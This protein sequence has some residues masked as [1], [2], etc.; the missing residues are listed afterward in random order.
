MI[1]AQGRAGPLDSALAGRMLA[2]T[3]HRGTRLSVGQRGQ[4]LLGASR[5]ADLVDSSL[6]EDGD[7]CAV[8]GGTLDNAG[9]LCSLLT[10]AGHGP[11]SR[12]AADVL[13]AAFR[14]YG[15]AAVRRLRGAFAGVVT[16]GRRLWCFRDHLG[17]RP[18]FYHDG[19]QGFLAATEPK[20]ILAGAGLPREPDLE[21]LEQIFYGR[22]PADTPCALKGVRRLPQATILTVDADGTTTQQRYWHPEELL[23]T[24]SLS[25]GDVAD[26]FMELLERAVART[27][28]GEDVIALSGGV[29]SPAIAAFAAPLSAGTGRPISALSAV[30]PDFPT[31][32]ERCYIELVARHLNIGLHT[33]TQQ[34]RALNDVEHWARL[35]D[36]PIPIVSLPE[37]SEHYALARALGFRNILTGEFAEF[38][39][40]HRAHLTGHLLTHGRF[41]A[42]A[43]LIAAERRRGAGCRTIVREMLLPF[44][45]GRLA[46]WWF[47]RV[48][49]LNKPLHAPEWLARRKFDDS[50]YRIDLVPPGHRRWSAQQLVAFDGATITMEADEL[51]A[52]VNGV[53]AR[54]PFG[55]VDLWEFFLSLPAEIKF[56]DTRSKT[57][58]RRLLRGRVPDAILDRPRK[59]VFDD[60]V[61]SQVDYPALRRL[62]LAPNHQIDGVDY[63]CLA[64]HLER[65][66]LALFDWFWAKEL[67]VVHAFLSQC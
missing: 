38:V 27:L 8:V 16:D 34:A 47:G 65:E 5:G 39:C 32:D 36:G 15:P 67:A 1:A 41:R 14:A 7:L 66:D 58:V 53:T 10:D 19:P 61:V 29:D 35:M 40:D 57:L 45:P 59:T 18:L 49:H 31:V 62:L 50:P 43:Q 6:S 4:C 44:L 63:R 20:Q 42:L 56:P 26:K 52:A 28:T 55:D 2:T 54:R 22:M 37:I 12:A 13:V 3:P 60:H 46:N 23:E 24:S 48:R 64:T 51:C 33:F 21:V 11:A 9:E 17:L 30:F 25:S